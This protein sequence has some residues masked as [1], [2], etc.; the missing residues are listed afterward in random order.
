M[1]DLQYLLR[2]Q[3]IRLTAGKVRSDFYVLFYGTRTGIFCR[4]DAFRL[5]V[6]A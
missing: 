1:P 2:L 6:V 4:R 3:E 5:L